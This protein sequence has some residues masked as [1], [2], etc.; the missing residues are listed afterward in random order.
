MKR[1]PGGGCREINKTRTTQLSTQYQPT[2][3]DMSRHVVN[4]VQ[5][6]YITGLLFWGGFE[7]STQSGP[8]IRTIAEKLLTMIRTRFLNQMERWV[9]FESFHSKSLVLCRWI[10]N[11]VV[12]QDKRKIDRSPE[13][14]E[15]EGGTGP[16]PFCEFHLIDQRGRQGRLMT[17]RLFTAFWC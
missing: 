13:E 11:A 4:F 7:R 14:C 6:R 12:S 15:R 8:F 10:I 5:S 1:L 17:S 9:R 2:R 16:Y 3:R